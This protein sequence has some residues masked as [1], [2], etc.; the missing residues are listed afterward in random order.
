SDQARKLVVVSAAG[1]AHKEDN[2][3][4]D[5]LYLCHAHIKY[6]ISFDNIYSIIENKFLNIKNTLKINFDIESELSSLKQE[7]I[8]GIDEDYL[9][10]RGEYLTGLLMAQYLGYKFVDPKNLIFFNYNGNVDY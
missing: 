8:K 6:G 9:I 2:K 1:K 3:I 4:T 7:L 5:L 10:S